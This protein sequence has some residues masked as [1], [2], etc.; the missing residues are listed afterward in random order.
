M[1]SVLVHM[2]YGL[3]FG[4]HGLWSL[5]C[6]HDDG[7]ARRYEHELVVVSHMAVQNWS[8]DVMHR[9]LSLRVRSLVQT[10][11][12]AHDSTLGRSFLWA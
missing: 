11:T 4:T 10:L 3:C 12:L 9:V 5:F 2:V 7:M 1:V 6:C 8:A